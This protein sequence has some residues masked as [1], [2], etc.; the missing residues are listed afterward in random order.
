MDGEIHGQ[1]DNQREAETE[2]K[3]KKGGV[4]RGKRYKQKAIDGERD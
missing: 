3:E 1:A 4:W 2:C